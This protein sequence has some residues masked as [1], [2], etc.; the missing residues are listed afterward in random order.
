MTR[1]AAH[2]PQHDHER[3]LDIVRHK[4]P[5]CDGRDI[6][7]LK[8]DDRVQPAEKGR[9]KRQSVSPGTPCGNVTKLRASRTPARAHSKYP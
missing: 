6:V 7:S 8:S 3:A 5:S 2:E 1:L 4:R 9:H